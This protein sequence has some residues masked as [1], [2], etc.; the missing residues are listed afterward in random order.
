M[1][2]ERGAR[3]VVEWP[4]FG[5]ARSELSADETKSLASAV[6]ALSSAPFLPFPD[7][8]DCLVPPSKDGYRRQLEGTD[9]WI[10]YSFSET[11]LK[12]WTI[13]QFDED[14]GRT[15]R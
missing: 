6:R 14:A 9:L 13:R 15:V 7:D 12:L 2:T 5:A 3:I 10:V 4:A 1:N 8:L 11:H